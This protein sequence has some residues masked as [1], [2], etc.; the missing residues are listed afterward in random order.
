M[1]TKVPKMNMEKEEIKKEL[2]TITDWRHPFEVEPG[3]WVPLFRDWHKDWHQWRVKVLMPTIEKMAALFIPG[4]IKAA[5]VLDIG[6]WDGFYGFEFMKRGAKFLK[7]IDLRAEALRRAN[8]VK[9]YFGYPNCE[10]EQQNIQDKQFDRERYDITL[11]YGVLYHLTAPID[12]L[13]RLGDIT[14]TMLLVNTYASS[15]PQ[16]ILKLKR[17]DPEKDSTGFQ[18]LITRPSQ[19]ALWEMLDFAGFDVI[20]RDYPYP[21]YERY[22]D[23]D[24]G[25]FYA[26]KSRGDQEK[27]RKILNDL[28]VREA[29]NPRSKQHQIVRIRKQPP[30][31]SRLSFRKRTGKTL[32]KL[33]DKLF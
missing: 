28:E 3:V 31:Q 19:A 4:G 12:V 15:E 9:E 6:C 14:T 24:F 2:L 30:G 13:K 10:F 27:V 33:I 7:G 1:W 29:Y 32:H 16:P 17:E 23:S 20:L 22:R 26:I 5:R 11:L 25:F 18:G 21:F 8:L